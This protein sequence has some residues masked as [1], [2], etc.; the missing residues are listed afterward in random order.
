MKFVV[1]N[2]DAGKPEGEPLCKWRANRKAD[3]L[4]MSKR[5]PFVVIPA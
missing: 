4:E 2:V 1:W 3:A 5:T